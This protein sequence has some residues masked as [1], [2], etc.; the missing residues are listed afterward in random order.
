MTRRRFTGVIAA[1][2]AVLIAAGVTLLVRNTVLKPT[3][4]TAYFTSATAIYPGDE[5]RVSGV[6]VGNVKA[7]EPQGTKAKITLA[8]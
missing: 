8:V 4:I 3:T 7:I 5:V 6:K 2:L 1:A